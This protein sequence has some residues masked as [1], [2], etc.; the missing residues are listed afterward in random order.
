M[1]SF[2]HTAMVAMSWEFYEK[3]DYVKAN[4][5]NKPRP[6][7][8][9]LSLSYALSITQILNWLIRMV[10][11][12]ETNVVAVERLKEYTDLEKEAEWNIE[13]TS[14]KA[15]WPREGRIEFKNYSTRY[16]LATT[17]INYH[18]LDSL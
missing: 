14:P 11:E 5:L 17:S 4:V 8:S 18:V 3:P 16:R 9:G 1:L 15:D 10:C 6:W 12:V 13:A 2:L 7:V